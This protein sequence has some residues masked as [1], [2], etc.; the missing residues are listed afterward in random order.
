MKR[1]AIV[2]TDFEIGISDAHASVTRLR[3][4][5]KRTSRWGVLMRLTQQQTCVCADGQSI[6]TQGQGF[7]SKRLV[8][9]CRGTQPTYLLHI[10]G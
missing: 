5:V 7:E 10:S 2:C 1:T 3:D 6:D 4:H 9:N 8:V